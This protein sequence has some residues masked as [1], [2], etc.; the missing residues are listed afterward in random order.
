MKKKIASSPKRVKPA[1]QKTGWAIGHARFAKI[2]AVEG[3]V[4]TPA[5]KARQ[6]AL[7]RAGATAE[8]RREAIMKSYKR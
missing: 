3:I 5:M 1:A 6:A 7:D 8:E 4:F 2:S